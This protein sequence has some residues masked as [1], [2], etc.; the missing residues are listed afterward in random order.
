MAHK[1]KFFSRRRP[2]LVKWCGVA[3]ILL[4]CL[5]LSLQRGNKSL[6]MALSDSA[7]NSEEKRAHLAKLEK[8]KADLLEN[9]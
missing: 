3:A 9:P 1:L 5:V 2:R 8:T 7:L 6:I 4:L